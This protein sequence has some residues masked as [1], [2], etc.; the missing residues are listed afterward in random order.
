LGKGASRALLLG[1]GSC[2]FEA[3]SPGM[4]GWCLVLLF[5]REH[6]GDQNG[7]SARPKMEAFLPAYFYYSYPFLFIYF[8]KERWSIYYIFFLLVWGGDL[9]AE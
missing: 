3:C 8:G 5:T 6:N 7:D 9:S 2:F 1:I 4:G